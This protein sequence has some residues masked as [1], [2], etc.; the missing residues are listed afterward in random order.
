[1]TKMA[2]VDKKS[3][4]YIPNIDCMIHKK[5]CRELTTLAN[6]TR[7]KKEKEWGNLNV[8][9]LELRLRHIVSLEYG[10]R[11]VVIGEIANY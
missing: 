11:S 3:L 2:V 10:Y 8:Y 7:W 5:E 4:E 6:S 9:K 1:M